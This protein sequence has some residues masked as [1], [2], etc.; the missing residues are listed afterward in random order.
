MQHDPAKPRPYKTSRSSCARGG[1]ML[2]IM[3]LNVLRLRVKLS[4]IRHEGRDAMEENFLHLS[5]TEVRRAVRIAHHQH[6]REGGRG[7]EVGLAAQHGRA[8]V[9]A[10]TDRPTWSRIPRN[11]RYSTYS[12]CLY[13]YTV[14]YVDLYACMYTL[15]MPKIPQLCIYVP[16]DLGFPPAIETTD[17]RARRKPSPFIRGRRIPSSRSNVG[18][19]SPRRV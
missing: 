14:I 10:T 4:Q 1:M 7:Q 8:G 15:Y 5:C 3:T 6:D 13:I 16:I 12:R 2:H 19:P 9:S 17:T 18:S 11:Y